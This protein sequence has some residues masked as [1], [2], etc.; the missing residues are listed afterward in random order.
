MSSD[1]PK[2]VV[3]PSSDEVKS[4][5]P[6]ADASDTT[7]ATAG[8]GSAALAPAD[9]GGTSPSEPTTAPAPPSVSFVP[10]PN[11]TTH[12][13]IYCCRK[14]RAPLFKPSQL[15]SHE[16]SQHD[17]SYRRMAKDREAS[18]ATELTAECTSYFL[19]E[20]V[21]WMKEASEDVEGKLNCP[22]CAARVGLLKWTGNQCSCECVWIVSEYDGTE[23]S[24]LIA[25][26]SISACVL[27]C[28]CRRHLGYTSYSDDKEKRR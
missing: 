6:A 11:A 14:C 16:P 7:L 9:A 18:K 1:E 24:S 3:V 25:P 13:L 19:E 27:V 26:Y 4:A 23:N 20:P 28:F 2:P 17:F 8:A 5:A 10:L 22:K 15:A 21:Q 12:D